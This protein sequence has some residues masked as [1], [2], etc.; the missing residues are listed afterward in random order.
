MTD[1]EGA[2]EGLAE[3][4]TCRR[5]PTEKD[6]WGNEPWSYTLTGLGAHLTQ[7]KDHAD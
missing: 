5:T 2:P 3:I 6:R 4:F 7:K 1:L